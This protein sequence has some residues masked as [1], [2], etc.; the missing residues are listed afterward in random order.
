MST[1]NATMT[2]RADNVSLT[3]CQVAVGKVILD[4]IC[5]VGGVTS[6]R[7]ALTDDAVF[8]AVYTAAAPALEEIGPVIA[9]MA[10]KDASAGVVASGVIDIVKAIFSKN[11]L[12][13]VLGAITD[14]LTWWQGIL[15]GINVAAVITVAA[16]TG[17]VSIMAQLVLTVTTTAFLINDCIEAINCCNE[18]KANDYPSDGTQIFDDSTGEIYLAIDEE[19]QWIPDQATYWN[20]FM[21]NAKMTHVP[22]MDGYLI[23]APISTNACLAQAA[24]DPEI[25]LMLQSGKRHILTPEVLDKYQFN[26]AAIK[27]ITPQDLAQYPDGFTLT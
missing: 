11:C 17:G 26:G 6:L 10:A 24:G 27:A 8:A 19:L 1:Q 18:F 15:F 13:A 21:P 12:S 23:G 16:T 25:Y 22:N 14:N 9:R 5:L 20:L 2:E 3:R 4:A 7:A